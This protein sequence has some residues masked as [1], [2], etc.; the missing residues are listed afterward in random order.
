M[1]RRQILTMP[2]LTLLLAGNVMLTANAGIY[3]DITGLDPEEV[4]YTVDGVEFSAELYYY[5]LFYCCDQVQSQFSANG[6]DEELQK[7]LTDDGAVNWEA[8]LENGQTVNAYAKTKAEETMQLH[9]EIERMAEECSIELSDEEQQEINEKYEAELENMGGE[10]GQYS[11][12]LISRDNFTK[13]CEVSYLFDE[14]TE[15]AGDEE[16]PYYLEPEK[17]EAYADEETKEVI[18]GANWADE[19]NLSE[20]ETQ[21][22]RSVLEN[23]MMEELKS[24]VE[25]AEVVSLE[26]LDITPG[27]FYNEFY[28]AYVQRLLETEE[29]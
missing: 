20:E 13:V 16:S 9:A 27:E 25:G 15:L 14:L 22:R 18:S 8:E 17:Y 10:D 11:D 29:D 3:T 7:Y 5:W 24:L 28:N 1:L 19:E 21:A 2:V 4:V 26:E 12:M 23:Y 6:S